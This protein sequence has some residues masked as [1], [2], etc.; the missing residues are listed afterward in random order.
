MQIIEYTISSCGRYSFTMYDNGRVEIDL[1]GRNIRTRDF[2][3]IE[4]ASD[5]FSEMKYTVDTI[6][7]IG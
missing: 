5:Y 2:S 3:S 1:R 4:A 6:G 7:R